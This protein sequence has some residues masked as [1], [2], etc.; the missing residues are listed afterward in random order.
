MAPSFKLSGSGCLTET[1]RYRGRGLDVQYWLHNVE[2]V[3]RTKQKVRVTE[4]R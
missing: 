4:C 3:R 2:A 1:L